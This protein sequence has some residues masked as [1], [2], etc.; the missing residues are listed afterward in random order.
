[1]FIEALKS[2]NPALI[3]AAYEL[4]QQGVILPDTYVI[5]VDQVIENGSRL[6]TEAENH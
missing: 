4:W 5:D 3:L 2:Q 6:L 1:M